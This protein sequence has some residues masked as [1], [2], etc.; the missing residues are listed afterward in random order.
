M[1]QFG[2]LRKHQNNPACT[3]RCQGLQ[4]VTLDII[5]KKKKKKKKKKKRKRRRKRRTDTA[6]CSPKY[7]PPLFSDNGVSGDS[8]TSS[9]RM[10]E[11]KPQALVCDVLPSVP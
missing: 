9:G 3:E 8:G 4:N 7:V 5:R 1:S 6:S 10:T 11:G 2:G